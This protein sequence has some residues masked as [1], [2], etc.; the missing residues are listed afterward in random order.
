L[1]CRGDDQ[2]ASTDPTS[3]SGGPGDGDGDGDPGDGDPGDGDGDGD[4]GDGDPGDGDGD[5]DPCSEPDQDQ[6]GHDAQSCGGLDCNDGDPTI[7]P[8][9]PD[10]NIEPE[11]VAFG[12]PLGIGQTPL[13]ISLDARGVVHIGY[14]HNGDM[15]HAWQVGNG[16]QIA[17]METGG[18][19]TTLARQDGVIEAVSVQAIGASVARHGVY[20]GGAPV[21]TIPLLVIPAQLSAGHAFALGP[22]D[23]PHIALGDGTNEDLYYVTRPG[24][25]WVSEIVDPEG[26]ALAAIAL[27]PQSEPHI[28]YLVSEAFTLRHARRDGNVWTI[29]DIDTLD[30]TGVFPS[31]AVAADGAAFLVWNAL[32]LTIANDRSGAWTIEEVDTGITGVDDIAIASDGT[33]YVAFEQY[34]GMDLM[35]SISLVHNRDGVWTTRELM[36]AYHRAVSLAI[37][38]AWIHVAIVDIPAGEVL[39]FRL[40]VADGIDQDCNGDEW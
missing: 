7:H 29:T 3:E 33:V 13:N 30:N 32:N 37:V 2:G 31:V 28:F 40:P 6:D 39:Y 9:A 5:G 36:P 14:N 20:G 19:Q 18:G 10:F 27:G 23:V 24:L 22:D 4:P 12:L 25:D 1:A 11:V 15:F 17:S 34:N 8:G 16:W 38:D 21:L 26:G 35:T